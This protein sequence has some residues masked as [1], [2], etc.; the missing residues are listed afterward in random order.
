MK[1][2]EWGLASTL[3]LL[4]LALGGQSTSAQS[5]RSLYFP[6]T[7]HWVR[8]E[9]LTYYES[10]S[11]AAMLFGAPITE[12]YFDSDTGT[13]IQYFEKAR[14]VLD[15]SAPP[16]L[17]VRQTPLGQ[18]IYARGLGPS[19][20]PNSSNCREFSL[21]PE[22]GFQVCY[23]FLDFFNAHGGLVQFGYPLSNFEIHGERVVQYF[24]NARFEWHPELSA[25]HRVVI[26]NLG[27][28]YFRSMGEDPSLL[29]PIIE[30]NLPKTILSLIVRA[31]VDQAVMPLRGGQ[32]LSVIVQDQ[33]LQPVPDAEVSFTLV[34]PSGVTEEYHMPVTDEYG[35]TRMSFPVEAQA[36]GVAEIIVNVDYG[37][38]QTNSRGSFRIWW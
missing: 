13:R 18:H 14:L 9:F 15:P 7:G 4:L 29:S 26:G 25:R 1:K 5:E 16:E 32:T 19:L 27:R 21:G 37:G 12:A 22:P 24:Q 11:E 17:R 3:I 20:T 8:D 35:V 34:L 36:H 30:N 38:M 2:T 10:I 6:E 33:N 28:E 31:F 23:A